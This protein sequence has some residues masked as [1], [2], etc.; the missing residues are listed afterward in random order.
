MAAGA[1]VGGG[2][3]GAEAQYTARLPLYSYD[4]TYRLK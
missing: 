4:P 3:G 1:G 2:G